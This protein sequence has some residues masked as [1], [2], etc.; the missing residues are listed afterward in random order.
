MMRDQLPI[1]KLQPR[2]AVDCRCQPGVPHPL[3]L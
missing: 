2:R 3:A 1:C